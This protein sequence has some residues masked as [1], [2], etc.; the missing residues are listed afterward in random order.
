MTERGRKLLQWVVKVAVSVTRQ[1]RKNGR[2]E[3]PKLRATSCSKGTIS[4]TEIQVQE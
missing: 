1:L 3:L 4:W 2:T